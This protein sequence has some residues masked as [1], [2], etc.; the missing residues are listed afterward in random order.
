MNKL[1][2][3]MNSKKLKTVGL[4]MLAIGVEITSEA[5]LRDVF[6]RKIMR[7]VKENA[8]KFLLG[9][10]LNGIRDRKLQAV[11]PITY[12]FGDPVT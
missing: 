3:L 9:L 8:S 5:V 7:V 2:D 6:E 4:S 1:D 10:L 11:D 12:S